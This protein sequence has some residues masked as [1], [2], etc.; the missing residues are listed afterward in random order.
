MQGPERLQSRRSMSCAP[1]PRPPRAPRRRCRAPSVPLLA[2]FGKATSLSIQRGLEG[3][4]GGFERVNCRNDLLGLGRPVI[5]FSL[6]V[7]QPLPLC[8]Y[9]G[10]KTVVTGGLRLSLCQGSARL[11]QLSH[12]LRNTGVQKGDHRGFG[13]GYGGGWLRRGLRSGFGGATCTG[14]GGRAAS[15]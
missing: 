11:P 6:C 1:P 10:L 13:G 15:L 5:P 3:F 8:C 2:E 14:G 4:Y 7:A 9:K 12:Q